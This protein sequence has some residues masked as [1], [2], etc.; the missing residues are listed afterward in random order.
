M[1]DLAPAYDRLIR[2][3]VRLR[4]VKFLMSFGRNAEGDGL[5]F[6]CNLQVNSSRRAFGVLLSL[7]YDFFLCFECLG[8][9]MKEKKV[10]PEGFTSR[11]APHFQG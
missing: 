11:L 4:Q 8:N 10:N 7:S 9:R 1:S 5:V 3:N 2:T 6:L